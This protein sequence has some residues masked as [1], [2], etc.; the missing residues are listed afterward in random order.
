LAVSPQSPIAAFSPNCV[1][2]FPDLSK[3]DPRGI[4]GFLEPSPFLV[5]VIWRMSSPSPPPSSRTQRFSKQLTQ[6]IEERVANRLHLRLTSHLRA[7]YQY[8]GREEVTDERYRF[9]TQRT[10][11]EEQLK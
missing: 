11:S 3:T 8:F 10:S 9:D 4:V 2:R 1:D 7:P 6:E 5:R